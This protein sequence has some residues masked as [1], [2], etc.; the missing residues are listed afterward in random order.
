[1]KMSLKIFDYERK[2]IHKDELFEH[3]DKSSWPKYI[4]SIN[5]YLSGFE[6]KSIDLMVNHKMNKRIGIFNNGVLIYQRNRL[7]KRFDC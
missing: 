1:M 2:N 6:L 5:T 7:I 4:S 3:V